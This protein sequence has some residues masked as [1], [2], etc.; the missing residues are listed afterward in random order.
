LNAIRA[1]SRCR[2]GAKLAWALVWGLIAGLAQGI[3]SVLVLLTYRACLLLALSVG[4]VLFAL[5]RIDTGKRARDAEN[6]PP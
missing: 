3:F 5:F 1:L 2:L 4:V 6:S